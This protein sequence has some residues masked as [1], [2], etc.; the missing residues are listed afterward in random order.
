MKK[1]MKGGGTGCCFAAAGINLK[2]ENFI[3]LI[4]F[5]LLRKERCGNNA[6]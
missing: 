2:P 6:K 5:L 3:N 1:R 4:G